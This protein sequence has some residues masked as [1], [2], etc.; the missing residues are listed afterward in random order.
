MK[1]I[2]LFTA[3]IMLFTTCTEKEPTSEPEPQHEAAPSLA[4]TTWEVSFDGD[5][6]NHPLTATWWFDFMSDSTVEILIDL[7]IAAQSQPLGTLGLH[8]YT[9][10]G[11]HGNILIDGD[12]I[13]FEYDSVSGTLRAEFYLEV[14]GSGPSSVFG[15]SPR[16]IP[17][18]W[19]RQS[20]S[21]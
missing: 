11:R 1:R 12:T 13:P 2:A 19:S 21:Q 16:S 17:L 6:Q 9:F 3:A 20:D 15:V 4:E 5:Y 14:G 8:Q 7:V 18:A 10:D